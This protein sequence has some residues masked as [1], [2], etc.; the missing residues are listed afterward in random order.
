MEVAE[1]RVD[2]VVM[3]EVEGGRVDVVVVELAVDRLLIVDVVGVMVIFDVSGEE[4]SGIF[5][6]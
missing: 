3:V 4:F 2:V 6:D 1:G 5:V